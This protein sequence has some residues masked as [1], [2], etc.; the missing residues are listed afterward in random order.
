M[1]SL[2]FKNDTKIPIT[3]STSQLRKELVSY[4]VE[5]D[6]KA[7][8]VQLIARLEL[9]R[10][11]EKVVT[12]LLKRKVI[13]Y[14]APAPAPEHK[15]VKTGLITHETNLIETLPHDVI[16]YYLI[17]HKVRN[18]VWPDMFKF[19]FVCRYLY[20]DIIYVLRDDAKSL[21]G[22]GSNEFS[23]SLFMHLKHLMLCS[24]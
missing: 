3:F 2:N 9:A 15:R 7:T 8:R 10:S 16:R 22:S 14:N 4:G 24:T 11:G 17:G 6:P 18:F 13:E 19:L 21:F 23:L 12:P 5:D 1:I 20:E